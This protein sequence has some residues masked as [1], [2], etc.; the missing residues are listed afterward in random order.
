MGTLYLY[1]AFHLNLNFSSIAEARRGEVIERCY[2]PLLTL[3]RRLG[4][5][6]GIEASAVTLREIARLDPAWLEVFRELSEEG[7][8]ELIGS[9]HA[10]LIGPLVPAD[11]VEANLG[12]GHLAYDALI[13][14]R[15]RLALVNEQAFSAGLVEHYLAAGYEG[16]L[17]DWDGVAGHHRDWPRERCYL[18]QQAMG[19]NGAVID[20]LWTSTIAFQKLQR[21]AHGDLTERDYLDYVLAQRGETPRALCLYG[22]DAEVFDFRPGRYHT[23]AGLAGEAASEWD[24]IA[25]AFEA[26]AAHGDTVFVAPSAVRALAAEPGGGQALSLTTAAAPIPVKKQPK[27]NVARWAVSGRDD[28]WAN[29]LCHRIHKALTA[30]PKRAD[31]RR[32]PSAWQSLCE[33][34][35]SDYRTHITPER[36]QAFRTALA[37]R[38]PPAP[39][40]ETR[41]ASRYRALPLPAQ[42]N[43][44]LAV[45]TDQVRTRFNLK[46]GLAIDAL[47]FGAHNAPVVG[48]L[49]HGYY[50]DISYGFDWFSNTVIYEVPNAPKVTDLCPVTPRL[51]RDEETGDLIVSA[52]IATPL[53]PISKEVCL[54][55]TTSMLKCRL[56][57]GWTKW[58][59]GS[60]RLGNLTLNPQAF[61]HSTLYY[62]THNGGRTAETFPL[63]GETVD[64]GAPVSFLVSARCGLGLTEGYM[65]IGDALTRLR[66]DVDMATAALFG[67]ITHRLVDDTIF[68]RLSLSAL[69][70]DETRQPVDL[71]HGPR[72]FAYDISA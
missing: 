8:V 15:P 2:W 55:S 53:G 1:A 38:A 16:V 66:L 50:D 11:V 63:H 29:T 69:E 58:A 61:D 42:T 52:Q 34:W 24:R 26:L 45:E 70:M 49:P 43:G 56:T 60:L 41:R 20:L 3:A 33:L 39:A 64:H 7:L 28:L 65:E 68:C 18:P 17:M 22:N 31:W 12:L 23:E 21:F 54:S 6:I 44:H 59:Q 47:W 67:L 51:Q 35:A 14:H 72:Q 10:Q 40:V 37:E 30:D 27:Y 32:D 36:W 4:A 9:G 5:P 48:T 71:D 46:K 62:R 57:L 25:T 19:A 13:G